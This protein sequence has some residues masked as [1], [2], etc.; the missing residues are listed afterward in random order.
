MTNIHPL[1]DKLVLQTFVKSMRKNFDWVQRVLE[2]T[3][4]YVDNNQEP[5]LQLVSYLWNDH[6]KQLIP[7]RSN[8]R[9]AI[10][11]NVYILDSLTV[12]PIPF[13]R[14]F[15]LPNCRLENSITN[16]ITWCIKNVLDV[17][18][19]RAEKLNNDLLI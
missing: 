3:V 10:K 18:Y 12:N 4:L 11:K 2:V 7:Q 14:Q 8:S 9:T 17:H 16:R 6:S 1:S 5:F 13:F 15:F 19:H